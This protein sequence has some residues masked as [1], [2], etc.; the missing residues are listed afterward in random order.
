MISADDLRELLG[1]DVAR[2]ETVRRGGNSRVLKVVDADGGT[3]AAKVYP[4]IDELGRDRLAVEWAALSFLDQQHVDCVPRPLKRNDFARLAVYSWIDGEP[5]RR[6]VIAEV[7]AMLDFMARLKD[8]RDR[9]G[10]E[11]LPLASE[12]C[13][14]GADIVQQV[15]RRY[16]RLRIVA[17]T[18]LRAFLEDEVRPLLGAISAK[19]SGEKSTDRTCWTLSPSDFGLHN[20]V[21]RP[22]GTLAFTDF[23][24]FGWDDP[25]KLAADVLWHPAMALMPEARRKFVQ[26]ASD[27]FADDTDFARRL[28]ARYSAF[29]LRWSVIVLGDFL[30]ERWS[31]RVH[32]GREEEP[33][34]VLPRQLALAQSY[35]RRASSES[36]IV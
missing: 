8:L 16:E 7:D 13:F 27:V 28:R 33:G 22:D 34:E 30:P 25:V 23:E 1:R 10:A 29:G 24:Y 14:R 11:A 12:A 26:G 32:A 35:V 18:D 2:L 17:D 36:D 31:I 5:V 9:P 20:A 3:Y 19:L 4:P 15:T 6:G 21:R